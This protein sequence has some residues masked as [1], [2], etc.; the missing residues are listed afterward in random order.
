MQKSDF[1]ITV[2]E[3]IANE[4][5][6]SA[7]K[8]R[9]IY[10]VKNCP[11]PTNIQSYNLRLKLNISKEQVVAY[12]VGQMAPHRKIDQLIK[13]INKFPNLCLVFQGNIDESYLNT[14]KNICKTENVSQRVFFLPPVPYDFIPSACQGADFGIFSCSVNSKS[15][16]FALPNKLFE[17]IAGGIPICSEDIPLMR[18]YIEKYKIGSIFQSN[19]IDTIYESFEVMLDHNA[20]SNMKCNILL[21]KEELVSKNNSENSSIYA[22]IYRS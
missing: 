4:L 8:E 18:K 10:V 19:N 7:Q 2:N 9:N 3:M 22:Q 20:L 15:M 12:Y 6:K 21:L 11:T 16:E 1:V 17:Y 5:K 13:A 14:L